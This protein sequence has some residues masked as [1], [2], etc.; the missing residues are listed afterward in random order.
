[1]SSAPL[2]PADL[3]ARAAILAQVNRASGVEEWIT[4]VIRERIELEE[5]AFLNIPQPTPRVP[6]SSIQS[7]SQLPP[8]LTYRAG[9]RRVG[10]PRPVI[11]HT[12]SQGLD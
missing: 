10:I 5:V 6:F 9:I 4:R 7:I 3:A 2:I 1:M 8:D 11:F 12:A